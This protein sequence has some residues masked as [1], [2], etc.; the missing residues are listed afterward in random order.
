MLTRHF[1]GC[2]LIRDV[3]RHSIVH[4]ALLD[5]LLH[6]SAEARTVSSRFG[7]WQGVWFDLMLLPPQEMIEGL[8]EKV[9]AILHTKDGSRV[10]LQCIW[11]GT[12]KVCM[13]VHVW[14]VCVCVRVHV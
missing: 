5:Y 11:H 1:H 10:A 3:V 4:R 14:Y 2:A 13:C 7:A 8:R 6:C 9:V 12:A